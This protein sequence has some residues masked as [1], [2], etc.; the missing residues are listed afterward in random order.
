MQ[1]GAALAAYAD[2]VASTADGLN[3]AWSAEK[4]HWS[5]L[6]VTGTTGLDTISMVNQHHVALRRDQETPHSLLG[7]G[8][9]LG[10]GELLAGHLGFGCGGRDVPELG[11]TIATT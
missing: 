1:H 11:R 9:L 7:S 3:R 2:F 4:G 5:P 6:T 10:E 8:R